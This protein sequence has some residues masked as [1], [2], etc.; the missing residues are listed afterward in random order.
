V[1]AS[2]VRFHRR[3]QRFD[4]CDQYLGGADVQALGC[5]A[6]AAKVELVIRDAVPADR[7]GY[8]LLT[9][10]VVARESLSLSCT[11]HL[12][13]PPTGSDGVRGGMIVILNILFERTHALCQITHQR[14]G[15]SQRTAP[16]MRVPV[17]RPFACSCI[18]RDGSRH[19]FHGG[20]IGRVMC[21]NPYPAPWA[22][23]SLAHVARER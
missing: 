12:S 14:A 2:V 11:R 13:T 22:A 10:R 17:S 4:Q 3:T 18:W 21:C 20:A 9:I 15:G 6:A 7:S 1:L 23:P 8:G 19:E 5:R 16:G